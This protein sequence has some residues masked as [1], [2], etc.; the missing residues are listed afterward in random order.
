MIF[1]QVSGTTDYLQADLSK[2]LNLVGRIPPRV[3]WDYID[4]IKKNPLKEVTV[5]RLQPQNNDEKINYIQF[6]S[7]LQ[8][9]NRYKK[10]IFSWVFK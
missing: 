7:Y 1:V 10:S 3:C 8:T 6:F 9:R 4:K 2:T 5:L